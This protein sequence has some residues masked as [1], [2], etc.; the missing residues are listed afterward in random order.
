MQELPLSSGNRHVSQAVLFAI[1][2]NL[3]EGF[4]LGD[5]ERIVVDVGFSPDLLQLWGRHVREVTF[6]SGVGSSEGEEG[7]RRRGEPLEDSSINK[8]WD[9]FESLTVGACMI[10]R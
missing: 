8:V 9:L 6:W 5:Q 2:H 1:R 3:L 4:V 10:I 7:M